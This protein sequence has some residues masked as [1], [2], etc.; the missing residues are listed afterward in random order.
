MTK[1]N[2]NIREHLKAAESIIATALR[3]QPDDDAL[4]R[5]HLLR[6]CRDV[7]EL[8]NKGIEEV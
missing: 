1:E 4:C 8:V 3:T 6:T 7:L 2:Q 5:D